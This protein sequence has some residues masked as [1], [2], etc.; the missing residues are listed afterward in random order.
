MVVGPNKHCQQIEQDLRHILV[1]LIYHSHLNTSID[2][3]SLLQTYLSNDESH[4]FAFSF[5]SQQRYRRFR[6][7]G[8]SRG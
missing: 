4:F 5:G 1:I 6:D 3:E 7:A 8:N 2:I